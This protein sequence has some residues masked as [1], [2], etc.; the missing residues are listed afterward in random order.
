MNNKRCCVCE[1]GWRLFRYWEVV[2]GQCC[3]NQGGGKALVHS[4]RCRRRFL[5]LVSARQDAGIPSQIPNNREPFASGVNQVTCHRQKGELSMKIRPRCCVC[6][7]K[8]FV[9]FF[10]VRVSFVSSYNPAGKPAWAH[11][12]DC[13]M[14]CVHT[15]SSNIIPSKQSGTIVVK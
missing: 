8:G 12:Q 11:R 10:L 14:K 4:G 15:G 2:I 7:S 5:A 13:F 3:F 6:N 9:W 1:K